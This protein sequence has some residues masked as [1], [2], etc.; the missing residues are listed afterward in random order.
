[1]QQRFSGW[2][3]DLVS[4]QL[5]EKRQKNVENSAM[6]RGRETKNW[7]GRKPAGEGGGK[8]TL[9]GKILKT[10]SGGGDKKSGKERK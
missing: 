4:A 8:R 1:M 5:R 2:A 6:L 3:P 9:E 10:Q 7:D